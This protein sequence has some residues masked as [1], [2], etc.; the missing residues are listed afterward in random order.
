MTELEKRGR[1]ASRY[2]LRT[3]LSDVKLIT[4]SAALSTTPALRLVCRGIYA[5]VG[6]PLNP[7]AFA[8]AASPGEG[9]PNRIEVRLDAD[10]SVSFPFVLTEFAVENKT[11]HIPAA[12]VQVVPACIAFP[13]SG[14]PLSVS[15]V[16]QAL[17]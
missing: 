15:T 7:T 2:E 6:W 10:G 17:L 5:L 16:L 1:V 4:L 11:L 8:R 12:G 14:Q 9:T 3:A 13:T